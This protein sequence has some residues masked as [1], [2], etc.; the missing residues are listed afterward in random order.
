[1]KNFYKWSVSFLG[2]TKKRILSTEAT[3]FG[4][5]SLWGTRAWPEGYGAVPGPLSYTL[6]GQ[7]PLY[8]SVKWPVDYGYK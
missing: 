5:T 7:S 8:G 1:M 2:N 4:E 3:L 6:F